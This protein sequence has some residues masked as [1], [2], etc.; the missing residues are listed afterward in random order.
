[1]AARKRQKGTIAIMKKKEREP[2]SMIP[3]SLKKSRRLFQ[4]TP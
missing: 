3:P 4:I 1:M 2:A